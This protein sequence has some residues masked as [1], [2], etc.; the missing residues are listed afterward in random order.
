MSLLADE[1]AQAEGLEDSKP[2]FYGGALHD[3][4]KLRIPR[5]VLE[6][7][8]INN[9]DFKEIKRHAELGYEMMNAKHPICAMIAASHHRI[10][11]SGY[12]LKPEEAMKRYSLEGKPDL[13]FC[14]QAVGLAD[15]YDAAMSRRTASVDGTQLKEEMEHA[16]HKQLKLV[17]KLF[18]SKYAHLFYGQGKKS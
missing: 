12:G 10:G 5:E 18:A 7:E 2:A 15:Y 4:G 9:S 13:K 17:P 6:G 11:R 14:A 16:F 1:L 8:A 3:A